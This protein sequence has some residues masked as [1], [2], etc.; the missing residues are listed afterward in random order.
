MILF[1]ILLLSVILILIITVQPQVM[2]QRIPKLT[3]ESPSSLKNYDCHIGLERGTEPTAAPSIN[4]IRAV[5]VSMNRM[6]QGE[7]NHQ[8]ENKGQ[9]F[10]KSR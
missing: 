6:I 5:I 7:T 8:G 9:I 4:T 2:A 10:N 3:Y 1:I